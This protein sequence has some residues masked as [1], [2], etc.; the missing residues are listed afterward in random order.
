M[1][2]TWQA[3]TLCAVLAFI[4]MLNLE[5]SPSITNTKP[6]VNHNIVLEAKT[7]APKS[8]SGLDAATKLIE[9]KEKLDLAEEDAEFERSGKPR[10]IR[11]CTIALNPRQGSL[12]RTNYLGDM[13]SGKYKYLPQTKC[14]WEAPRVRLISYVK[15]C[16]S[17]TKVKKSINAANDEFDIIIITGD[18][19]CHIND[20]RVHFRQY[21]GTKSVHLSKH[22][23]TNAYIEN[24]DVKM[25]NSNQY[26]VYIPLG[27]REEFLFERIK[28]FADSANRKYVYNFLGSMT[29][30]SRAVLRTVVGADLASSEN[31]KRFPN[32]LHI[33]DKWHLTVTKSNGYIEPD[34]YKQVL[35]DS[36][37]TLCPTG[38]NPE[39][40]RYVFT[41]ECTLD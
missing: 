12:F 26:P 25:M 37:F 9:A 40:Y 13:G 35:L 16:T 19:Y 23:P 34:K 24:F 32:F 41:F 5:T 2:K 38:H 36:M 27:P 22:I 17:P 28:G 39:A 8:K 3:L 4:F 14:A 15:C 10:R 30:P 7:K 11:V 1:S 21:H 20:P 6:M 18:E 31:A 33:T 29:S